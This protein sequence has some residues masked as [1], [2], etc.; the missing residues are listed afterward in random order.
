MP[1]LGEELGVGG[2]LERVTLWTKEFDSLESFTCKPLG[3]TWGR[4]V[5]SGELVGVAPGGSFVFASGDGELWASRAMELGTGRDVPPS[6]CFL[7]PS[8]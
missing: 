4:P 1:G 8:F 6:L 2:W 5:G 3:S 7:S